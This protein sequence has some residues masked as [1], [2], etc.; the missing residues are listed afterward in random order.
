MNIILLHNHYDADHLEAVKAEMV[1]RGAPT[2]RAVWMEAYGAW[3][4]LEGCHR[5]R[6]AAE[7]GL[8]P[9]IEEVE[10]SEEVTL[11]DI[12]ALDE[13]ADDYTIAQIC[14]DAWSGEQISFED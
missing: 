3:V 10:Y 1:E 12:G 8:T 11:S 6:A 4:A 9:V 14:D 2:I 13:Y 7:L 5:L